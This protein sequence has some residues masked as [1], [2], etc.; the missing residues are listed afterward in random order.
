MKGEAMKNLLTYSLLLSLILGVAVDGA[1]FQK[2]RPAAKR[3]AAGE[4]SPGSK[5]SAK[6]ESKAKD[7]KDAQIASFVAAFD[8]FT[9]ELVKR[10]EKAD[11]PATG[12]SRA[13]KYMET[14]KAK[15]KARFDAVKCIGETEVRPETKK[16]LSDHFYNDGVMIGRLQAKYGSDPVI[17]EKLKKLTNDFLNILKIDHP[18]PKKGS[19]GSAR[20]VTAL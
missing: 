6:S 11:N 17:L 8:A 2:K 4:L 3:R 18:C 16:K 5:R 14:E 10:V 15:I 7:E 19:S 20:S 9:A 12:V 13:Q 1:G